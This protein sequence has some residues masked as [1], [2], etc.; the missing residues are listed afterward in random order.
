MSQARLFPPLDS[1]ALSFATLSALYAVINSVWKLALACWIVT[2]P[3]L[4][5]GLGLLVAGLA[6]WGFIV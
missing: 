3:S 5:V 2:Y 1:I 6:R 4:L